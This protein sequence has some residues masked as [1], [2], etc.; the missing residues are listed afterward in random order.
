MKN[1]ISKLFMLALMSAV[2]AFSSCQKE[3]F[4]DFSLSVKEVGPDFVEVMVTAPG[5]LEMAYVISEES[6]IVTPAVLF[7]TGEVCSVNPADRIRITEEIKQD[8]H[9]YLY[10]VAKLDSEN[11]SEKVTLEFNTKKYDFDEL[12]T[13]VET[14]YDGFKAHITV[15]EETK[16]RGNAIRTGS[17]PLAWYNLMSNSKGQ[18][19]VD[20]QA[21]ASTGDPYKGHM[22]NDSTIVLN[23]NNVVLLDENGEPVLDENNE[24]I[25]IHDPIAP[26]EPLIIFAGETQYGTAD[27]FNAIVGYQ[28]PTLDSW[29]VP[30]YDPA[31]KKW[32][33]AFQKKEFFAKEPV[34]CDA[35]VDVE[36]PE[37]EIT[38]TDAMIYFTMSDDVHSYFYMILDNSTYNQILSIYLMGN[39]EWYQ[40]FLTSYIG[41][42]E[43]GIFPVNENLSV[44]AA[45][46]FVEPLTGG[47]TY[48]VL[49]TVFGDELGATQRFIHKTFSAKE[50]TKVAPAI[51][52]TAVPSNDPY[53]AT[54]NVKAAADSKGNI[55][56]IMGAYWVCNYSR[57]FELLFNTGV[58]YPTLLKNMGW[59]FESSELAK[60]NTPEG[61]T[62]SFP[63]LDGEVTR[64]AAYGCNDEYTF[65]VIDENNT[66][67][68]AD[69]KAPI[70]D[71]VDPVSS[72]LFEQLQG[73]WTATA[74]LRALQQEPDGTILSYN[75]D[76][77]SKITITD[78]APA[79]PES[80]GES[81]YSLYA[82]TPEKP[83]K[84][85][86]EVDGMFD[87]LR[88]LSDLFTETRLKGQN[89]LLCNGFMDFDP[90]APSL[91]MNRLEYRSPYDLF[92]DQNYSS[93]DIAQL[94]Y[95]FGPKW[96]LEIREDGSVIVPF[97]SVFLPPMHSWPG[98]PFYV[99]GVGDGKAFY[100]ATDQYPGFPVEISDDLNTITIKPIVLSD[101]KTTYSYHMNAIGSSP[102][103]GLEIISTVIT[104][105]VLKRGWIETQSTASCVES[106]VIPQSLNAI[107]MN[108]SAVYEMPK[109]AIY[110]SMTDFNAKT[111][112]EYVY[113]EKAN[114]V[115]KE[116]V[117]DVSVKILRKFNLE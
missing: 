102:Q 117:D 17:M 37:D 101:G 22:F 16:Q 68:W 112:P 3:G 100:D 40:W 79:L 77:T 38:V 78:S 115:T 104:D 107:N 108:S 72:P 74:T 20:L 19:V 54:F 42:Y 52:V 62:I 76:H 109:T 89:R 80:L 58:T 67:G 34:L 14:Y 75:V 69:Y 105:I 13:I 8:T 33:G 84:S 65:N 5:P 41:F 96:F 63:T 2:F 71:S 43:W 111:L 29:A 92:V 47:D 27:D 83:G 21:I 110:K 73:E 25:D 82:G 98:Y 66:L 23:N 86:D 55:Q 90:A 32:L 60:I 4:G 103:G 57:D 99:G 113:K 30:Y 46:S 50:K 44:N 24:Q 48:H 59:V 91:D 36:I 11:Y 49:V 51:E 56:P 28:Q 106:D 64:F 70:A 6:M 114:V 10:A 116:M 15:P 12:I 61:L 93:I 53:T 88:E 26:G 95:D 81:V 35:T 1:R 18:S 94:I 7:R 9:Y 97:H 45:R 85:K 87:E 31:N 39:E